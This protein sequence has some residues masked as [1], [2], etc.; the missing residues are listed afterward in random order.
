MDSIMEITNR[1]HWRT[2][3]DIDMAFMEEVEASNRDD[4]YASN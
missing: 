2:Q 1:Y 3:E 4:T